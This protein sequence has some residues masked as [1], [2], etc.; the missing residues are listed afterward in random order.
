M[1]KLFLFDTHYTKLKDKNFPVAD[2]TVFRGFQN[3]VS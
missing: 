3:S 1:A 2:V